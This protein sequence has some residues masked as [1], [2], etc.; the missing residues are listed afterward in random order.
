M[1]WKEADV[2]LARAI[3]LLLKEPFMSRFNYEKRKNDIDS[4]ELDEAAVTMLAGV[5][6]RAHATIECQRVVSSA[7]QPPATT[8]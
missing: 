1:F 8:T 7:A 2:K 4:D 5:K 6:P 3:E